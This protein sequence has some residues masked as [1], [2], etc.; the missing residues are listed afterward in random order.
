MSNS[1]SPPTDPATERTEV[2]RQLAD[3]IDFVRD[4]IRTAELETPEDERMVIRWVRAQ[5]YLTGQYRQLLKDRDLD[6]MQDDLELLQRA[7]DIREDER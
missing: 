7:Q 3:T 1:T 4:R 2:R 5:G 6:E